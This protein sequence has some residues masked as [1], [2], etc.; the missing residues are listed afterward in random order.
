MPG[1]IEL[2]RMP[3]GPSSMAAALVMPRIAHLVATYPVSDAIPARPSTLEALMIEP[4]PFLRIVRA[5]AFMPRKVPSWFT[6]TR[7]RYS[8]LVI[9]S[10]SANRRMPALFRSEEHTSELQSQFHLVCRLLLEKK[11]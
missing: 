9:F 5:T 1:W 8:S 4:P 2:T 6:L 11:K 10:I 3:F 7:N